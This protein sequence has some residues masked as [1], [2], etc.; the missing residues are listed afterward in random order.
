[1]DQLGNLENASHGKLAT[2]I[3]IQIVYGLEIIMK[4]NR[5]LDKDEN[6]DEANEI[7]RNIAKSIA[8]NEKLDSHKSEIDKC[9]CTCYRNDYPTENIDN[10][11][12]AIKMYYKLVHNASQQIKIQK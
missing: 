2:Y 6:L 1:M 3:I 11:W 7:L 10:A 8:Q 12:D 5:S 4:F 9:F